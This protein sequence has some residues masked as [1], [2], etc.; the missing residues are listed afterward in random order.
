MNNEREQRNE[1]QTRQQ[2]GQPGGGAG[3]REE[4]GGSGVHPASGAETPD[5]AVIRTPGEWGTGAGGEEGGRSEIRL[6]E[7]QLRATET[8]EDQSGGLETR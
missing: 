7:E 4:V 6:S 5:D 8:E 1:D 3:R 2:S